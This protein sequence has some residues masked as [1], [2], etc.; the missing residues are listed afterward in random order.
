MMPNFLIVGA[1]KAG[2]TSLYHYL[3]Q[4]PDIY[5]SPVKEPKYF[6]L[7]G[8]RRSYGGPGD[9]DDMDRHSVTTLEAY[10]RLFNGA[11]D[12]QAAGEAS[13]LYLY[14]DDAAGRIRSSIPDV[15]LIALLRDP[16]ERAYSNFLYMVRRGNEPLRTFEEGLAAEDQRVA[17]GWMP[18]WHYRRRGLYAEQLRRYYRRFDR[19]QIRVYLYDDLERRPADLV[20][21]LFGFLDVDDTFT[22]D[23]SKRHNV[24]GMPRHERV[25]SLLNGSSR[26]TAALRSL[27]PA[28]AARRM[29]RQIRQW[30]LSRTAMSPEARQSLVSFYQDDISQ[31]EDMIG[32]DLSAWRM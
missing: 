5:L 18:S 14:D 15:R 25:H 7:A 17:Q 24:S 22:P 16:A 26:V 31:L 2:T 20:R 32:R 23:V 6:A 21:D 10:R 11:G 8:E 1:A 4:H 29:G 27:V 28:T 13:T 30:N 12:G 19:A 9:Q 3:R